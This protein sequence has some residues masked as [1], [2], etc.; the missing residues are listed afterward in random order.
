[1]QALT[2]FRRDGGLIGNILLFP[3]NKY[4]GPEDSYK[5]DEP[6]KDFNNVNYD[7]HNWLDIQIIMYSGVT[8]LIYG[9][10]LMLIINIL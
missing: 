9:W 10:E 5:K 7:R 3:C 4:H 6:S 1:M 2:N 8:D